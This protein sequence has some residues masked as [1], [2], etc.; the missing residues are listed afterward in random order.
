MKAKV[1][2]AVATIVIQAVFIAAGV[3]LERHWFIPDNL[4]FIL[5]G[6]ISFFI[7][8]RLRL[9]VFIMILT[10][11]FFILHS[12]GF[13]DFYAL[14]PLGIPYDKILHF[15]GPMILSLIIYRTLGDNRIPRWLLTLLIVLGVGGLIEIVEYLGFAFLGEGEGLFFFGVGDGGKLINSWENAITD[16]MAN[17]LGSVAGVCILALMNKFKTTKENI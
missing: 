17:V 6:F 4:L 11:I 7:W 10:N 12:L 15:F 9:N 1:I 13:V 16:L 3:M 5:L 2:S 8:G 14:S